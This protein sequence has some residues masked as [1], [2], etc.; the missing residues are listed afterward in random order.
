MT[1]FGVVAFEG[2]RRI[3][4]LSERRR[5]GGVIR[6]LRERYLLQWCSSIIQSFLMSLMKVSAL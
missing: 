5:L 1:E 6:G 3:P 2:D 4:N